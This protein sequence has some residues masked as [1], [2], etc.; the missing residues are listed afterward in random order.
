MTRSEGASQIWEVL[1]LAAKN[2]QSLTYGILAKLIGVAPRG[3][4]KFLE[5]IQSYCL[6]EGM[7]P[8][9]I[10]VVQQK[11]GLPGSGFTGAK[12]PEYGENR[13]KVFSFDWLGHGNPQAEKL[14][15]AAQQQPSNG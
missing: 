4:G 8:L 13:M 12:V 14:E 6:I 11:T 3:L 10:L 2:Q 9:T 7:P 1:A 15:Q 5:P